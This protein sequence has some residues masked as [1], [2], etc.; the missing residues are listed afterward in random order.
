MRLHIFL[1]HI[2]NLYIYCIWKVIWFI[3]SAVS[4]QYN[5]TQG[6]G[7]IWLGNVGC[8]GNEVDIQFCNLGGW[9]NH[10]CTHYND[11]GL[12]CRKVLWFKFYSD[13]RQSLKLIF[14]Y[15]SFYYSSSRFKIQS[16]NIKIVYVRHTSA[17]S[18]PI[19]CLINKWSVIKIFWRF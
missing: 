9:N 6:T 5:A 10:S 16:V 11:V 2:I 1:D 14:K 4:I 13:Q 18:V 19:I 8:H 7:P 15:F 17:L 3:H 12:T